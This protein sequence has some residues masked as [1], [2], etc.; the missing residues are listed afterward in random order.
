[1]RKYT[2]FLL[3]SFTLLIFTNSY[4]QKLANKID[5]CLDCE[6]PKEEMIRNLLQNINDDEFL[7]EIKYLIRNP[8]EEEK[9]KLRELT[10]LE[11][12]IKT[13]LPK[14][15]KQN[16]KLKR[17]VFDFLKATDSTELKFFKAKLLLNFYLYTDSTTIDKDEEIIKEIAGEKERN[18]DMKIT[19]IKAIKRPTKKNVEFLLSNIEET[20]KDVD[21]NPEKDEL[22]FEGMMSLAAIMKKAKEKNNLDEETFQGIL[23]KLKQV[24]TKKDIRSFAFYK[25]LS[26]TNTKEGIEIIKKDLFENNFK[27]FGE[28]LI[29][30]EGKLNKE[31]VSKMLEAYRK[32]EIPNTN[33]SKYRIYNALLRTPEIFVTLSSSTEKQDII[34]FIDARKVM[35]RDENFKKYDSLLVT[36]IKH[37]DPKIRLLAMQ[38]IQYCVVNNYE[39]LT[40][41]AKSESDSLIVKFLI[42]NGYKR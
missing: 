11:Y 3:I 24:K 19:A 22:V 20:L 28:I 10:L 40:N 6:K 12:I 15:I 23:E 14:R 7:S 33:E 17:N 25:A 31:I 1:M 27:E 5:K 41:V 9:T 34:S 2:I 21:R 42:E 30:L 13:E 29:V 4:S 35:G 38:A 8:S 37:E 39:I 36:F 16:D 18:L 26:E 32:K